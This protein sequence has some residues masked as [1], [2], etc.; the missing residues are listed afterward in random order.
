MLF[1]FRNNPLYD[2]NT[3]EGGA[4][5]GAAAA[6]GAIDGA[7][8]DAQPPPAVPNST[9]GPLLG[10]LGFPYYYQTLTFAV[11]PPQIVKAGDCLKGQ[12]SS[13][14][15]ILGFV[16]CVIS[17][18]EIIVRLGNSVPIGGGTGAPSNVTTTGSSYDTPE[19][20]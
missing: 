5:T 15:D 12:N 8:G 19:C 13:G 20:R 11:P 2:F 9:N 14:T 16:A 1:R 3:V 6:T 18:Q 10:S 17:Q 7:G 4:A